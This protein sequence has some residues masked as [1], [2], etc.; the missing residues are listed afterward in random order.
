MFILIVCVMVFLAWLL[1]HSRYKKED[2]YIC[3]FCGKRSLK[4]LT[5]KVIN[6][7]TPTLIHEYSFFTCEF[8]KNKGVKK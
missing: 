5:G 1:F 6:H 4:R 8:C 7:E 3:P 2:I